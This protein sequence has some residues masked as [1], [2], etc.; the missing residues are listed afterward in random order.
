MFCSFSLVAARLLNEKI[1]GVIS[2]KILL[3]DIETFVDVLS[4]MSVSER[5]KN[6][7]IAKSRADI[8]VSALICV[9]G[10]MRH[11]GHSELLHTFNNLRYG[12]IINEH[13]K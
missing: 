8:L 10:L 1:N 11:L 3:S 2:N 12:V 13:K 7:F 5:V 6:F 9:G 4:E